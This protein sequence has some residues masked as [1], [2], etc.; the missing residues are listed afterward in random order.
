MA[1][2]TVQRRV[3]A[4]VRR[5]HGVIARW[6]LA[7]LGL[8]PSAIRHRM[9]TGRLRLIHRGVYVVGRPELT[10]HGGW[11]AAVLACGPGAALSHGSAGALWGIRRPGATIHVSVPAN[12]RAKADGVRVHRRTHKDVTAKDSIPLTTPTATLIDLAAQH[13]R[14]SLEAAINEADKLDLID[15]E[16]LRNE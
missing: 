16:H 7:E 12:R 11:M 2:P 15:P 4:L 5:Q 9:S 1:A 14:D 3:W 13:S 8:T 10:Q 6:Q